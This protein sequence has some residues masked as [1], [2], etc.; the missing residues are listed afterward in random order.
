MRCVRAGILAGCLAAASGGTGAG[1]EVASG[2]PPLDYFAGS[3]EAVGRLPGTASKTFSK[4]LQ[5][6]VDGTWLRLDLAGIGSG[7][8]ALRRSEFEG[9]APYARRLGA[10]WID[11]IFKNDPD[12]YPV[13]MCKVWAE[14]RSGGEGL[15][16]FWPDP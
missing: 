14:D 10:F 5:I 12:N 8:L 9:D 16:T 1:A 11:C 6:T 15:V 2:Q 13:L 3:Y 7:F 4:P